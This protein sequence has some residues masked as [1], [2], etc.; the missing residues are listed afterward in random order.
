MRIHLKQYTEPIFTTLA[1][2][3]AEL[4]THPLLAAHDLPTTI[5]HEFA[6]HQYSD[7]ILWIPMLAQMKAKALRSSR[8]RR[9][10]EDNIAHEAGLG[11]TSH[12]TL[13]V[14]LMRSLGIRTLEPFPTHTFARSATLWLSDEFVGEAEPATAGW[15]L[16]A[17]TLVP[18]LFAALEPAFARIG[19][20]TRYF[21]EHVAVDTDEHAQWMTEAVEE[22]VELYGPECVA[23]ILA[24]M[25]DAFAETLEVPDA[26]WRRS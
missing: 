1:T 15:L 17:E 13:A 22:I 12:V 26:L 19:A 25:A 7:S 5:L 10:I 4:A 18:D 11:G 21:R 8:L 3:R 16:V 14:E 20:D 9:A 24:G 6:F 23:D 2:Q